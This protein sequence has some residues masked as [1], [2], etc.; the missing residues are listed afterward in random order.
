MKTTGFYRVFIGIFRAV[1][2]S[3]ATMGSCLGLTVFRINA[4][5]P[6]MYCKDALDSKCGI[7]CGTQIEGHHR[8]GHKIKEC[9]KSWLALS[10]FTQLIKEIKDED[11][12]PFQCPAR[13]HVHQ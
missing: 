2:Q 10:G 4:S 3:G 5:D 7:A 1:L 8:T 12:C 11:Q 9:R 13:R 6:A